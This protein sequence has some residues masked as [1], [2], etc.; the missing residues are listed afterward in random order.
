MKL[1]FKKSDLIEGINVVM[2]AVSTKSSMKIL[3]CI[4]IDATEGFI[5]FTANDMDLGI[6]TKVK[7]EIKEAGKIAIEARIFS[8]IVRKLPDSEITFTLE[9]DNKA[10]I[11]CENSKFNILTKDPEDFSPLP[12][13]EKNNKI[14]ISQLSLKNI[15]DQTIFA[16]NDAEKNKVLTGE[17]FEIKGNKL[18]VVALDK[19]RIA[20]RNIELKEEYDLGKVIIPGKSLNEI[21]KI[22]NGGMED[23]VMIYFTNNHILFDLGDTVVVSRLIEDTNFFDTDKMISSDYKTKIEINKREFMDC[24]DRA[25]L[26]IKEG[27]SKPVFLTIKDGVLDL[28]INT[29]IG[30][31]DEKIDIAKEGEDLMISFNPKFLLDILKVLDDEKIT[32]YMTN[33]KAPCFIRNENNSYIYIVLPVVQ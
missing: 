9:D 16:I 19:F 13:V 29:F 8:E 3:E 32:L 27:E 7:G 25:T 24:I 31:M 12:K 18:K 2:K 23:D 28:S 17:L 15:I 20:I 4:L 5:K 33:S 21:S 26:L 10:L 22:L 6:E 14:T 30:T 11:T 1:L